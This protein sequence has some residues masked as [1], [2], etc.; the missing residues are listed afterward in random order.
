MSSPWIGERV[1]SSRFVRQVG[2][3]WTAQAIVA[4]A[5]VVQGVLVA[6]WLGPTSFGV[7]ALIVAVP[8]LVFTFMDAR[9]SEAA[10]RYLGE[11]QE[12]GDAARAGAFC[13]LGMGLDLTA[14]TATL[15]IV[16]ATAPWAAEHVVHDS[17]TVGLLLV[18]GVAMVIRAPAATSEAVLV[19]LTEFRQL[20]A[21]QAVSAVVRA[22]LVVALV[23]GGHGIGG[24][25]WG[26]AAGMVL[27]GALMV[28]A[29]SL[30]ARRAWGG[31]WWSARLGLLRERAKEIAHF[32]L[33]SD[34]GSLL[35]VVAKQLDLILVGAFAGSTQAGYYR[36]AR[37]LGSLGGFVV[38]PVQS[39]L[40][41]RFA[42][43]RG[44]GDRAGL[45]AAT[46]RAVL[47]VSAPLAAA[48][49]LAIPFVPWVVVNLAGP[50]YG[51]AVGLSQIMVLL[52]VT[53]FLFLWVRPL[54][55][56]LGEVRLW[57]VTGLGVA[58]FSLAGFLLLVPPFE[59]MGAAWV[60]YAGSIAAQVIPAWVLWR[61]YARGGYAMPSPVKGAATPVEAPIGGT[62]R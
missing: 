33:W 16:A 15:L 6:R 44:A 59:A 10:V 14:A 50:G 57:A 21:L 27:E 42:K 12:Q 25:V 35:G 22:A 36:L 5:A 56:T 19:T 40:Y 45:A 1:T 62:T 29:A 4:A 24:M 8:S 34:A 48:G 2:A 20:A 32:V 9:A 58:I 38:G 55:L 49:L 41:Q 3:L 23:G 46:R 37:S 43:L 30:A 11:F 60:R 61:R 28:V 26:S 51:P 31:V 47:W 54:V 39:V 53:W 17:S 52:D 7:A 18:Y 13:K